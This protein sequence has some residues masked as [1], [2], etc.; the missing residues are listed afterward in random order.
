[1]TAAS[2]TSEKLKSLHVHGTD[3]AVML[4]NR[5]AD[6]PST[7]SSDNMWKVAH[8]YLQHDDDNSHEMAII[9]DNYGRDDSTVTLYDSFENYR[10][11]DGREYSAK[12]FQSLISILF[13]RGASIRAKKQA[14]NLLCNPPSG[15][16][17]EWNGEFVRCWIHP[18]R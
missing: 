9:R 6:I 4:K 5:V 10:D 18:L 7:I 11:F 14:Y 3:N 8:I 2:I 12:R 13:D 17:D 16:I 1:M 15:Y